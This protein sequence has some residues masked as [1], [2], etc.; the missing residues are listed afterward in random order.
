MILMLTSS[1]DNRINFFEILYE[2]CKIGFGNCCDLRVDFRSPL[3]KQTLFGLS[4]LT[5]AE[6][7]ANFEACFI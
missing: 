4:T 7:S 2:I 5:D 6:N 1:I 3:L